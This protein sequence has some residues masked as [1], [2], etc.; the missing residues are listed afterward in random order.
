MIRLARSV[1]RL[2]F[3][4]L[5]KELTPYEIALHRAAEV[6]EPYGDARN[7][8][9]A[10]MQTLHL[11]QIHCPNALTSDQRQRIIKSLTAYWKEKDDDGTASPEEAARLARLEFA[12][13]G[14]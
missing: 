12:R 3:W 6:I 4:N 1:G 11:V 9:R 5:N 13:V 7:D 14:L 2:D 10:A 8:L